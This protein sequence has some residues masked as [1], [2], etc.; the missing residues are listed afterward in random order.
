M[1]QLDLFDTDLTWEDFIVEE[2]EEDDDEY[3]SFEALAAFDEDVFQE[4]I[5]FDE[6]PEDDEE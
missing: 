3:D 1:S 2:D 5:G 6:I 4:L